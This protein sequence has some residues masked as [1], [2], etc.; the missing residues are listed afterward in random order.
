MDF[1]DTRT[2]VYNR[3]VKGAKYNLNFQ[4]LQ[5]FGSFSTRK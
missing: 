3:S 4:S 2:M 5:D 1:F